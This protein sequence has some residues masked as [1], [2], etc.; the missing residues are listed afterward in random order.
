MKKLLTTLFSLLLGVCLT[1]YGPIG[2]GNADGS[3]AVFSMEICANG[4]ATTILVGADGNPVAPVQHCPECLTC[5][6]ATGI[7]TPEICRADVTFASTKMEAPHLSG[8]SPVLK[9]RN[10]LPAPRGPPAAHFSMLNVPELVI[11]DRTM[12]VY[13]TPSDGRPLFKDATA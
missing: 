2:M 7:P 13:K 10:I 1:L 11:V 8:Q 9:V 3:G 12:A 4:V 5:C 6:H